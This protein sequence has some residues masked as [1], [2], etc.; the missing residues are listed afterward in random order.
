MLETKRTFIRPVTVDDALDVYAYASNK[1]VSD[2]AGYKAHESVEETKSIIDTVLKL[3]SFTIVYKE[4]NKV[5]G[6][7]SLQ[8]KLKEI[9]E[10]GYSL[11][12]EY[13][14]QGIMT[15]VL[16]AVCD[17]A[18]SN[19]IATEID[20]GCFIDNIRSEKVLLKCGFTYV[21]INKNDY[22]NYDGKKVDLKR[23]RLL[24]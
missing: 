17:Y 2:M 8:E 19:N 22:R 14:D 24:K 1:I 9:Y 21:G 4:T 12:I 15:E 3:D 20:A 13:W 23:F 11:A 16:K 5:I 6:T 10:V 7:I 18:F